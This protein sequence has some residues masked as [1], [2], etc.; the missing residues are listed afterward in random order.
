MQE[1]Q[2]TASDLTALNRF[3]LKELAESEVFIF[4][5]KFIDSEPTANGRI[6]SREWQEQAIKRKLFEGIP[7][8]TNHDNDQT[9]KI[10]TVFSAEL[11]DDGIHGKVFLPLDKQGLE[12]R[13]QVENG[14]I[15]SV[16][17][18]AD[19]E[20][21]REGDV[22]KVLPSDDMRVFEVSAVAVPGCKTC[23]ITEE[24]KP[25]DDPCNSDQKNERLLAFAESVAHDMRSDFVRVAGFTLGKE[26]DRELYAEIATTLDPLT[27]KA[28]T[29]D[30]RELYERDKNNQTIECDDGSIE[31]IKRSLEHIH[32]VKGV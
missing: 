32:K 24:H 3:T 7:F 5:A 16:S 2:A 9:T 22:T 10:G 19:G 4:S 17:I 1:Q 15:R 13:E 14:R 21:K 11:K 28:L 26:I 8:L 6:W 31:N 20:M 25:S 27:L 30:L 29:K 12:S 23:V 18:N